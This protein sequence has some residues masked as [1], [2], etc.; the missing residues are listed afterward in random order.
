MSSWLHLIHLNF[1]VAS[2]VINIKIK[3]KIKIIEK[4]KRKNHRSENWILDLDTKISRFENFGCWAFWNSK[5]YETSNFYATFLSNFVSWASS[6]S[7]PL[8]F[9]PSRSW[10]YCT[11]LMFLVFGI[12]RFWFLAMLSLADERRRRRKNNR[13]TFGILPFSPIFLAIKRSIVNFLVIFP[14]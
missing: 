14:F 9:S 13:K 2:L 7:P 5:W 3:K 10:A 6:K 4:E 12:F 8:I 1:D 11:I